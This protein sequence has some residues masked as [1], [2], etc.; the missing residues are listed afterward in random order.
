MAKMTDALLAARGALDYAVGWLEYRVWR[1]RVPGAQVAVMIGDDLIVN[2]AVG[3][4]D[5]ESE[6]RLGTAHQF[7]I[8]SH[9][10]WL[11]ATAF[12]RLAEAD[13]LALD[14][15]AS[16]F[17]T[18]LEGTPFADVTIAELLSH[19]S[20]ITRDSDDK[21]FWSADGDFPD[22]ERLLETVRAGGD[23]V[24]PNAVFKYS[25]FGF[26]LLGLVLEAVTERTYEE[27]MRELVT[28]PLG[29]TRT[30]PDIDD[31]KSAKPVTGHSG[32]VTDH[33]RTPMPSPSAGALHAATGFTSTAA[34]LARF[35]RAHVYGNEELLSDRSKARMQRAHWTY[36]DRSG[37]EA[38]YGLG[39]MR[40][41]IGGSLWVGHGGSWLGQSTRTLVEPRLGIVITVLTNSI[42]GPA[43]ELARGIA[44]LILQSQKTSSKPLSLVA[45]AGP[46]V[47]SASASPT[48]GSKRVELSRFMGRFASEWSIVDVVQV[49]E[50][51]LAIS[52]QSPD[53]IAAA[54]ELTVIDEQT[55]RLPLDP[56]FDSVGELL[57]YDFDAKGRVRSISGGWDVRPASSL[58]SFPLS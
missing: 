56:G 54:I 34:E 33:R 47:G 11:T 9:S 17:V 27:T 26:G 44:K 50:R 35:G 1:T 13:V 15:P 58:E 16:A 39:T 55:L 20:G 19:G 8:A 23:V 29:L 4:A 28:R 3:M 30:V 49:G 32:I 10:K 51:L 36:R 21:G 24:E 7:R 43:D 46:A 6:E 53:P 31:R 22:R 48:R 14:D 40:T 25:N 42:D 2:R 18:E 38:S 57:H 52:P 5:T 12:L 41:E 37:A 45:E